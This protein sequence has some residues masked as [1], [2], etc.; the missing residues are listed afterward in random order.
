VT[1]PRPD[2]LC[3]QFAGD[4]TI[5]ASLPPL[6]EI[7]QQLDAEPHI[8]RLSFNA[9]GLVEW[10]SRFLTFLLA[11]NELCRQKNSAIDHSGLPKGVQGLLRLATAVPERTGARRHAVQDSVL[12]RIGKATYAITQA[13]PEVLDLDRKSVV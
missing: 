1:R 13:F 4:W 2:T 10:D 6:T 11:I 7:Q 5:Q 12:V 3:V 8:Q 9:E